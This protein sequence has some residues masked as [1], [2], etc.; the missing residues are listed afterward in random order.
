MVGLW[1]YMVAGVGLV[2][3]DTRQRCVDLMS[4]ESMWKRPA[5]CDCIKVRKVSASSRQ[6][7]GH[8]E[9]YGVALER[10]HRATR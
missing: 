10:L 8:W 7:C 9:G 1:G 3:A 2:C 5:N 4:D 6:V